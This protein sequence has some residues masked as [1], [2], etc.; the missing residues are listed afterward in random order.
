MP[1][2]LTMPMQSCDSS[3][4]LTGC[5]ASLPASPSSDLIRG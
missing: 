5:V 4:P 2:S 1:L 3:S